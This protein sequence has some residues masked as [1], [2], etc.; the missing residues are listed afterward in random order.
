LNKELL[1]TLET[2]H[3]IDLSFSVHT[4]VRGSKDVLYTD[5]DFRY[6]PSLVALCEELQRL[7]DLTP[8]GSFIDDPTYGID[9]NIGEALDPR[10]HVALTRLA[11]L[12]ALQHPSFKSRLQVK[13]MDAWWDSN[14]P[15]AIFVKGTLEVYG[16]ENIQFL[17]FGPYALKYLL[18]GQTRDYGG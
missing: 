11:C 4:G 14:S 15:N 9:W 18:L 8:I 7:F 13:K 5:S 1:T 10:V 6:S 3:G 16:F 12:R 2:V 17:N